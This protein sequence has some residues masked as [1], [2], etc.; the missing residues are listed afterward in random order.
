MINTKKLTL[1]MQDY[2]A[3]RI[4]NTTCTFFDDVNNSLEIDSETLYLMFRV[5]LRDIKNK[6]EWQS[7]ES[8]I[9]EKYPG[10]VGIK[11]K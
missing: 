2:K 7:F 10:M 8:K 9:L 6:G 1:Y 11:E 4:S 5:M 3:C